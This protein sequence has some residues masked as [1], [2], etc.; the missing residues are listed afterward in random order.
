MRYQWR[1][2]GTN[3]SNPATNIANATN[4][5]L[6]L[7]NVQSNNAGYYSLRAINGFGNTNSTLA[8]LCLTPICVGV[9]LSNGYPR[10][11]FTYGI[12]GQVY[13]VRYQTNLNAEG[14]TSLT[15]VTQEASGASIVDPRPAN[16]QRRFYR[17]DP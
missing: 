12:T 5:C 13:Q 9:T 3:S 4:T 7:N 10:L 14:W 17:A 15:T 11:S 2:H 1:F 6:T 8:C 16:L